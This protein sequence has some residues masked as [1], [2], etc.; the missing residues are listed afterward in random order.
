MIL[1]AGFDMSSR[2]RLSS[3]AVGVN[4]SKL[5]LRLTGI[6]RCFRNPV[7]R[8]TRCQFYDTAKAPRVAVV[9]REFARELFH[10]DRPDD[11]MGRYFKDEDGFSDRKH[12]VHWWRDNPV[13]ALPEALRMAH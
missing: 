7:T 1:S 13:A 9:N 3:N 2:L 11:A 4:L 6:F 8:R 10:S 12:L 5:R